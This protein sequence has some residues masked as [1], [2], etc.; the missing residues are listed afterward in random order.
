MRID[1]TAP[2]F[3]GARFDTS[4][5]MLTSLLLLK[6]ALVYWNRQQKC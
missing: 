1:G 3:N 6:L 2:L 5:T 4:I